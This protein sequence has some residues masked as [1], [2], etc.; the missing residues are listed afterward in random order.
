MIAT[1][2]LAVV[3]SLAGLVLGAGSILLACQ[4]LK[5][6]GRGIGGAR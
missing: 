2:L 3:G 5:V 4:V 1:L 6:V